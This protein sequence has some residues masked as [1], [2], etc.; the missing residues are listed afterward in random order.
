MIASDHVIDYPSWAPSSRKIIFAAQQTRYGPFH[1]YIVDLTGRHLRK[2][3]SVVQG[4]A[5]SG[6]Q[7]S[8]CAP[9]IP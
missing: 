4:T 5:M 2:L 6:N 1:L 3:P 9:I 7:P 8:W